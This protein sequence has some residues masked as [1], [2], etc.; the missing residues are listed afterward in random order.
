MLAICDQALKSESY[1]LFHK[2]QG[3]K[4]HHFSRLRFWISYHSR[5]GGNFPERRCLFLYKRVK[6]R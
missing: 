4:L 2:V 3:M 6:M 5:C 1:R